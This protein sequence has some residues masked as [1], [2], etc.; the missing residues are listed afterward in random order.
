MISFHNNSQKGIRDWIGKQQLYLGYRYKKRRIYINPK[1]GKKQVP[2]PYIKAEDCSDHA[3]AL[4]YKEWSEVLDAYFKCMTI[5]L[6]EGEVFVIP[7]DLGELIMLKQKS[8]PKKKWGQVYRN[9][10]TMGFRPWLGWFRKGKAAFQNQFWFSSINLS[11]KKLWP[12]MGKKL[13][14]EPE[15]IFKY[16]TAR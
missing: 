3:Y 16:P 2:Q 14:T 4:D 6:I 12:L 15:T 7:K 1:T 11:R 9:I 5:R 8:N 10:R 13:T